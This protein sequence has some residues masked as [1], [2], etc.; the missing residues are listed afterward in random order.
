MRR[1]LIIAIVACAT[2]ASATEP[3]RVPLV[4]GLTRVA[5]V[6]DSQGDHEQVM[7]VT[8]ATADSVDFS[9]EFRAASPAAKSF[10][11]TRRDRRADLAKSNRLNTVFQG[12]DSLTFPGSTLAHLSSA[13]LAE[14][15]QTGK[16]AMVFGYAPELEQQSSMSF[17]FMEM[18][19]GRK[20][21]RGSLRRDTTRPV[22]VTV[23]VNGKP[24]ALPVVNAGGTFTV[25]ADHVDLWMSVLDD[26]ANPLILGL[27]Q[28]KRG[29]STVR[30]DF[31]LAKPRSTLLAAAL[32]DGACRAELS[33][34]YFD[35]GKATLLPQ[36][37]PAL[38]A[39]AETMQANPSWRLRI[40]GHTD[41]VGTA[42][43]NQVLSLQRA[44]AVVGALAS[45]YKL[46][47][48]R[49]AATGLGASRPVASNDTLEGRAANRRVELSRTC[50]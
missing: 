25:G 44:S 27:H 16:A 7:S 35:F 50:P 36:S 47:A 45:G 5:A 10:T 6:S 4:V 22:T 41:S 37:Q 23:V 49:F 20:Y 26:P 32:S 34:I 40:E 2:C 9:V 24:V 38:R 39:V 18:P 31:P 8:G 28:G 19:S 43:S 1:L 12:G 30:L 11:R 14:L 17:G 48:Q 15:K 46:P 13:T 29:G 21:Y 42:A 33:G 3:P